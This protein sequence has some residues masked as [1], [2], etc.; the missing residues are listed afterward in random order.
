ML[1][2]NLIVYR[3][4]RGWS[5]PAAGLEQALEQKTLRPCGS[6]D[7]QTRGF[8]A[9]SHEQRLLHTQAGHHLLALGVEQKILPATVINQMA[10]A[11][12]REQA[13]EQGHPV[14]RRQ[15]R[16]IKARVADELRPRALVRQRHTQA[17]LNPEGGWLLVNAASASRAE[18]VVE[19]LRD[20][21]GSF[22]VQPLATHHPAGAAMAGWLARGEAPGRFTIDQDLEL[23]SLDGGL[24]TVRYSHHA[25]DGAEIR[26]H[27]KSGKLPTRLGLTWNGRISFVLHQN[28]QLKPV[29]FLDVYDDPNGRGEN[30]EEQFLIDF[31]LMTGEL[32][33]LVDELV[34]ALGG[35]AEA[36]AASTTAAPLRRATVA[37]P[38]LAVG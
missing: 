17:W 5:P 18:E 11:R 9:C 20:A 33:Q 4:P 38:V 1:F 24:A 37:E 32:T 6:F 13:A 2:R 26:N 28:L 35:V 7:L 21:L 16:E 22:A 25:L 23:K 3:L 10:K 8:V 30:A 36:T 12:A 29:R 15:M 34:A 27:L 31:A 14:G 19:S